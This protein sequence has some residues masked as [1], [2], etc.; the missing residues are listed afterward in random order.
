MKI[1]NVMEPYSTLHG[2]QWKEAAKVD[3]DEPVVMKKIH[4]AWKKQKEIA[5][6]GSCR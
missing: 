5:D 3:L 2:S 6:N 4:A 1:E